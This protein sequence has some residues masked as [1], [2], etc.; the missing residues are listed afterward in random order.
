MEKPKRRPR[1]AMNDSLTNVVANLGTARDKAAWSTYEAPT[2]S[3]QALLNAYRGAWL[4]RKIVDIPALD[5]CRNW[6]DWQAQKPEIDRLEAE[7]QRLALKQKVLAARTAARLYGGAAL[8]IVTGETDYTKPLRPETVKQGGL[9][10]V[11]LIH[12]RQLSAVDLDRDPASPYFGTPSMWQLSASAQGFVQI[13]PSRL[14]VFQGAVVP[15]PEVSATEMGWGDPVLQSIMDAVLA[16]DATAANVASLVFEAKVDT[17][18]IPDLMNKLGDAGYE[19]TL[20]RRWRLAQTG[21][22]INGALMHDAEEI[23]GQKQASFSALPDVLDRFMQ[24]AA[25]AADIPMTRLLGMSPAGMSATGESDI[26]NYYDRISAAQEL[27]MEP[28]LAVLDECLIRSALGN[29]PPEVHFNWASLWQISATERAQIGKTN[30]ETIN[31]LRTSQLIP[32]QPLSEAAVNLMTESGAM[33]GLEGAVEDW[34]AENP[35]DPENPDTV[36]AATTPM[37]VKADPP[38]EDA[39]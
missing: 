4:P 3:A 1:A 12:K 9:R 23:I 18:G 37:P 2:L 30:A 10:S 21:K 25:G 16:M 5:S 28:A 15:D 34:E 11:A 22:G 17:V 19:D 8:L 6:R 35:D 33:P 26:R 7:E 36:E 31:L 27:E 39:Q 38:E 14:A 20:L 24:L 32:D 29:R 13:H